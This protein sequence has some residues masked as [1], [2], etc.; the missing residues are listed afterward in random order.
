MVEAIVS[1]CVTVGFE[2]RDGQAASRQPR[3]STCS[4]SLPG[5]KK[6]PPTI[7]LRKFSWLYFGSN[8][9]RYTQSGALQ[10]L[11]TSASPAWR[12]CCGMIR[13]DLE[14]LYIRILTLLANCHV[15]VSV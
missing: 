11:L 5:Q 13:S 4:I 10:R 1:C 2:T 6:K 7:R 15:H 9:L 3:F 12:A 8:T 14:S